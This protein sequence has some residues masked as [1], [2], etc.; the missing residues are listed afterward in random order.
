[1]VVAIGGN[2]L[3]ED[4]NNITVEAQFEA[5]QKTSAH[6]VKLVEQGH[7]VVIVHGNGPQVGYIFRR[8]EFSRKILHPVPLDC[9]VADTRGARGCGQ[10]I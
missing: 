1:M 6:I 2:S 7:R 3:I 10:R 4:P 8:A 5:A 9:C